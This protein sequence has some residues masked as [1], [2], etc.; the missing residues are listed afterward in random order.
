MSKESPARATP[1]YLLKDMVKCPL[2]IHKAHV[3]EQTPIYSR[4]PDVEHRAGPVFYDPDRSRIV[5]NLRFKCKV[6][7]LQHSGVDFFVEAD[8]CDTSI[9]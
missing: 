6:C 3:V 7:P 9:F 2:Q 8:E 1:Q 5:R 4:A